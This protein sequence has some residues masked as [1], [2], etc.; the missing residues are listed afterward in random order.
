VHWH[1]YLK[2][3]NFKIAV[4][5]DLADRNFN[6]DI[7]INQNNT[8]KYHKKYN[9]LIPKYCKKLLGQKYSLFRRDVVSA[10]KKIL[11]SKK[12][13]AKK[14][15]KIVVFM[16]AIDEDGLLLK[17]VKSKIFYKNKDLFYVLIGEGNTRKKEI[18]DF[19]EEYSIMYHLGI[20]NFDDL[21][22]D[23][24]GA[25]I[26][27]GMF[28]VEL[29][30]LNIPSVLVPLSNVQED[31]AIQFAKDGNSLILDKKNIDKAKEFKQGIDFIANSNARKNVK[32]VN[33]S[34]KVKFID[35]PLLIFNVINSYE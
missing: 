32:K 24:H 22:S 9:L 34:S 27:C 8:P 11:N 12:T 13:Q 5:D 35:G 16:G 20:V 15:S 29:N 19:C 2:N 6:A 18:I 30:L 25:F 31:V 1:N 33:I 23:I 26:A 4:I 10:Y 7:I 28:A 3:D 17:L 21:I 14:N